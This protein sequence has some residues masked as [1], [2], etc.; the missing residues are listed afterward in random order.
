MKKPAFVPP[1]KTKQPKQQYDVI[2]IP[3]TEIVPMNRR[4]FVIRHSV[5]EAKRNSG[6]IL[7]AHMYGKDRHDQPVPFSKYRYYVVSVAEDCK[8]TFLDKSINERRKVQRGDE[9][10]LPFVELADK[11]MIPY[12]V[13][14]MTGGNELLVIDEEQVIGI[15]GLPAQKAPK[16]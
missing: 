16:Q 3:P 5:S 10:Y 4:L 12:I 9:I 1:Q 6:I 2:T 7:P 13:D 14:Y 8:L 11:Y 15:M